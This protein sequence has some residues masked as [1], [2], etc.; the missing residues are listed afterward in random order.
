MFPNMVLTQTCGGK[1]CRA[2]FFYQAG[3][4]ELL[5]QARTTARFAFT[6]R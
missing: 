4:V 1:A 3:V 5:R 2:A 6:R